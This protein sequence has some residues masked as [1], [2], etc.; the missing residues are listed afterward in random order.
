MKGLRLFFRPEQWAAGLQMA[1]AMVLQLNQKFLQ[2][3]LFRLMK[4]SRKVLVQV[5]VRKPRIQRKLEATTH[6]TLLL[7]HTNSGPGNFS[8][9]EDDLTYIRIKDKLIKAGQ[10]H[11]VDVTIH[12]PSSTCC[13][14]LNPDHCSYRITPLLLLRTHLLV[15]TPLCEPPDCGTGSP[16]LPA[17]SH[18]FP[19]FCIYPSTYLLVPSPN[20]KRELQ[21]NPTD[22]QLVHT[23]PQAIVQP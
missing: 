18:A 22:L 14:P 19:I 13:W 15:V 1:V 11:I 7:T 3:Q 10:E 21:R 20:S 2:C 9:S 23:Q 5:K 4:M 16:M 17:S 6:Q 8:T 12:H